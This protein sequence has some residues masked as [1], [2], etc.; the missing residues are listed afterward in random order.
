MNKFKIGDKVKTDITDDEGIVIA[1]DDRSDGYA[2]VKVKFKG[3]F[4]GT[5]WEFANM[6]NHIIEK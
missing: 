3:W 4:G 5:S 6:L 1:L 2:K